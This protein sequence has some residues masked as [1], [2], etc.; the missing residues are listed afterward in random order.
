MRGAVPEEREAAGKAALLVSPG[1]SGSCLPVPVS[2]CRLR[3]LFPLFPARQALLLMP[4]R[5][6]GSAAGAQQLRS[7]D[8]AAL[9]LSRASV[10][11]PPV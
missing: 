11:A 2:G 10:Q 3:G 7:P 1:L 6:F 5:C 9:L 8:V 4:G